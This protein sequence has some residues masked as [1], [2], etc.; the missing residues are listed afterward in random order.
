ME[1]AVSEEVPRKP[2]RRQPPF[3]ATNEERAVVEEMVG[4]RCTQAEICHCIGRMRGQGPIAK[5]T[6]QKHFKRELQNGRAHLKQ[7]LGRAWFE[8][9]KAGQAWAIQSGMR[10]IYA[11]R[12][13]GPA[14]IESGDRTSVVVRF[15]TPG[16]WTPVPLPP[17]V[18][19]KPEPVLALPRPSGTS[20][21]RKGGG[22][23]N[24]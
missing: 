8:A 5:L 22:S 10:N 18:E 24:G 1:V 21:V 6:F 12:D 16:S 9:V 23:W 7:T 2:P 19:H 20:A 11:W 4:L 15:V 17:L 13:H 14:P 3:N